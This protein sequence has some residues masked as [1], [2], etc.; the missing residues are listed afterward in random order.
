[1]SD[2]ESKV[3]VEIGSERGF[4]FVF[5]AVFAI[6]ALWPLTGD[7][8]VRIWAIV[9]A[10]IFL[11]LALIAPTTLKWPNYLWFKFG[12]LLGAIIAPIVMALVFLTTFVSIGG[13]LRLFGKDLLGQKLDPDAKS[14]WINRTDVPNSMKNQF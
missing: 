11:N 7:G 6:I 4:G 10:F 8:G 1:M 13:L 14:Y 12:L 9:V 3:T 5:A 2:H